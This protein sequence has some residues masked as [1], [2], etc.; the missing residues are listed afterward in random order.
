M[1]PIDPVLYPPEVLKA[2]LELIDPAEAGAGA[3]GN[4]DLCGL[5]D[6]LQSLLFIG[7]CDASLHERDLIVIGPFGHDLAE[8][9]H[10]QKRKKIEKRGLVVHELELTALARR[11]LEK[12]RFRTVNRHAEIGPG[13]CIRSGHQI[14]SFRFITV[15]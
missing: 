7:S 14:A 4:E 3:E 13:L 9:H 5:P 1:I 12:C 10:L 11:K 6:L 2:V 15:Q 8:I